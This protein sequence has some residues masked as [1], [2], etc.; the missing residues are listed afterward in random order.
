MQAESGNAGGDIEAFLALDAEGLQRD[1]LLE[2]PDQHI[3]A[4]ADADRGFRRRPAIA[5]LECAA[6][7]LAA[8]EHRPGHIALA[9]EAYI[10]AEPRDPP[11]IEFRP[12]TARPAESAFHLS[13]RAEDQP[14]AGRHLAVQGADLDSASG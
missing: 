5:A 2:A 1:R 10:D 4:E 12:A 13:R 11:G 3:G 6:V 14:D 8:G 9:G 7:R